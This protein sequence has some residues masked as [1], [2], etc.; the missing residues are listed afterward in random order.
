MKSERNLDAHS[1]GYFYLGTA[2]L[3]SFSPITLSL[4]FLVLLF[5]FLLWHFIEK[6]EVSKAT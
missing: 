2:L 1:F 6:V 4:L 5:W 3:A